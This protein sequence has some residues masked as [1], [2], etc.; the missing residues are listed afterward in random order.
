LPYL[1]GDTYAAQ[2]IVRG[3]F[4]SDRFAPTPE[5]AGWRSMTCHAVPSPTST[6]KSFTDSP[7]SLRRSFPNVGS[8]RTP[9]T[10]SGGSRGDTLLWRAKGS[11]NRPNAVHDLSY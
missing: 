10:H 5:Y 8:V 9:L 7:H 6:S 1:V 3:A 2:P 4:A 11:L